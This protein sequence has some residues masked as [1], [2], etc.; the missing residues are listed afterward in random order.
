MCLSAVSKPDGS[1]AEKTE[2]TTES[3]SEILWGDANADG[4]IDVADAVAVASYVGDSKTN[5]L[6]AQGLVNADVHSNGNGI[7]AND[8][9]VIQQYLSNA[10]TTLP[11]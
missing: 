9:L 8:A 1:V 7:N 6:T 4:S 3:S 11:A 10:I 2:P 5:T